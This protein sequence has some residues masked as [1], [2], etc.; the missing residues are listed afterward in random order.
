MKKIAL[1]TL[2]WGISYISYG[3]PWK[4]EDDFKI[5]FDKNYEGYNLFHERKDNRIYYIGYDKKDSTKKV[6]DFQTLLNNTN[7]DGW[8]NYFDSLNRKSFSILFVNNEAKRLSYINSDSLVFTFSI[9]NNLLNG[10]HTVYYANGNIKEYGFYKNNARIGDWMFYNPSGK[11]ISEGS[12]EGDYKKLLY[13]SNGNKL[14]TLN[15][16]LDT[17]KVEKFTQKK[18]D[19]LKNELKQKWGVVFP[20]HY[21]FKS[22]V[23]KLYDDNGSLFQKEYYDKGKLIKIESK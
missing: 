23:W 7:K 17:I 16:Y 20:I 12:F 9:N 19:S 10:V 4:I 2:F 6:F 13:D 14:I 3:Q 8:F 11:L 22:G 5:A 1:I 21:H 18:Y 15:R